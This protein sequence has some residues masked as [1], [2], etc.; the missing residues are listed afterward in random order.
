MDLL[1]KRVLK[2]SASGEVCIG[3]NSSLGMCGSSTSRIFPESNLSSIFVLHRDRE[4]SIDFSR[5][6]PE[7]TIS[8]IRARRYTLS[9]I[10]DRTSLLESS[11]HRTDSLYAGAPEGR[12]L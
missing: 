9:G 3:T 11:E 8:W 1:I 12:D 7:Y 5:A 2:L 6:F 4:V 10:A